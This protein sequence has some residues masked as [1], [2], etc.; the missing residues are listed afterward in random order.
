MNQREFGESDYGEKNR[1]RELAEAEG[2]QSP[3]ERR[4]LI[5]MT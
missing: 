4:G 1:V 2:R 5:K 3:L